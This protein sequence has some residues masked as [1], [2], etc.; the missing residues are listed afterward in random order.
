MFKSNAERQAA[1]AKLVEFVQTLKDG[2]IVSWV[3]VEQA[4]GVSMSL[5]GKGRDM[6]RIACHKEGREYSAKPG[7]GF[8]MSSPENAVDLA[9]DR[10]ERFANAAKAVQKTTDRLVTR[11]GAELSK[12]DATTLLATQSL[13][14]MR[15]IEAKA[16]A[17]KLRRGKT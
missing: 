17:L 13:F 7:V 15:V 1:I 2:Q 8:E 4:T 14:G 5:R 10:V 16:D 9:R 3:E 12:S 11:H 6:L